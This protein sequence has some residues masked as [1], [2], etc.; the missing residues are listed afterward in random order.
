MLTTTFRRPRVRESLLEMCTGTL[1]TVCSRKTF[2]TSQLEW[3]ADRVDIDFGNQD[4]VTKDGQPSTASRLHERVLA[5]A[6]SAVHKELVRAAAEGQHTTR[7][8]Y[9]LAQGADIDEKCQFGMTA[10]YNAAFRGDL[11]NVRLLLAYG[12]DVNSRMYLGG[13]PICIA[14]LRGH[15]D[16]VEILISHAAKL[17]T[18]KQGL[19]SA[20]H[21]ACFS[22]CTSTVKFMLSWGAGMDHRAFLDIPMLYGLA[23]ARDISAATQ[24][25]EA[26]P[27]G[28]TRSSRSITCSPILLLAD[29]CH[30]DLL[31]LCQAGYETQPPC[32][33]DDVWDMTSGVR[34]YSDGVSDYSKD[35]KESTSSTWSFLGFPRPDRNSHTCTLLMWA[36]ASLKFDL[37]DYL[38]VAGAKVNTQDKFGWTALHHA[39]SPFPEAE[40]DDFSACVQ[41]LVKGGADANIYD[42]QGRT[43]LML[44][45]QK[46]HPAF[47]PRITSKWGPDLHLKCAT[48]LLETSELPKIGRQASSSVLLLAIS[49]GCQ[50][51]VIDLICNHEA[52]VKPRDTDGLT[53]TALGLAFR[54]RSDDAVISILLR[55]GADPNAEIH[56]TTSEPRLYPPLPITPLLMAIEGSRSA[57]VVADLLA[58]GASPASGLYLGLT[59]SGLAR[60]YGRDDILALLDAT[61]ITPTTRTRPW[62]QRVSELSSTVFR[63][64]S[65]P[66]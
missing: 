21:C 44:T 54:N 11:N 52:K 26:S 20:I 31:R 39:A 24:I 53:N 66:S 32:S 56:P 30:F 60:S 19:D 8:R 63:S 36:A 15:N 64:Y 12:A 42:C 40:F 7:L 22:G 2:S 65:K 59:V 43:P 6:E 57:T 49:S 9:L 37:I 45:V 35:S 29:R 13:S 48:A 46:D 55:H 18:G 41:R 50:P 27:Q 47:D 33:P 3:S 38:L 14:A 61:N 17:V 62:L 23:E 34:L 51:G 4:A 25:L 16:V 58:H 1:L 28:A 10:L 5:P